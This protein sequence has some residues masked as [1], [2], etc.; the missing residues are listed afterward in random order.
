MAHISLHPE[1]K[2]HHHRCPK[3]L[4]QIFVNEG[5]NNSTLYGNV[6]MVVAK[7]WK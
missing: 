6:F 5:E 2:V 4:G 3:L 7:T 1:K